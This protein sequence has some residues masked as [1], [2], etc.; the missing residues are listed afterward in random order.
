[1]PPAFNLSQDQTLQFKSQNSRSTRHQLQITNPGSTPNS[2]PRISSLTSVRVLPSLGNPRK[3]HANYHQTKNPHL[4][5]VSFLKSCRRTRK[6]DCGAA[7]AARGAHYT[8]VSPCVNTCGGESGSCG[9]KRTPP[10]MTNRQA[11][12]RGVGAGW[13]QPSPTLWSEPLRLASRAPAVRGDD[14]RA[15]ACRRPPARCEEVLASRPHHPVCALVTGLLHPVLV[16]A[17]PQAS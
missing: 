17:Q 10:E 16:P 6:S 11:L 12:A 7:R 5:V 9:R 3:L 14:P 4:S 1:M 2:F 15:A 8:V 13:S